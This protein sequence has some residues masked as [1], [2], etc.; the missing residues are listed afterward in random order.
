MALCLAASLTE[1]RRFDPVDQLRRYVNW[2]EDGYQACQGACIDMGGTT[3][4][5]LHRFM[6]Q[7][8]PFA[9]SE[10]P[11][12]SGNGGIMRL[13]PAVLAAA[14]EASA[15]AM[16]IDSSRTTHASPDCL[17]AAELLGRILWRLL[18]GEPLSAVLAN[19]PDFRP[20][21]KSISRIQNGYFR[22]LE[23]KEVSSTGY[24]ISTL[25]AALWSCYHADSFEQALVNAVNLGG[26]AD[27]VGAVTGQIA[28]AAFGANSI[29]TRWLST[30]VWR[31]HLELY[32]DK[33]MGCGCVMLDEFDVDIPEF[34]R[35]LE[36]F[37]TTELPEGRISFDD[38]PALD[39]RLLECP[40]DRLFRRYC[41]AAMVANSMERGFIPPSKLTEYTASIRWATDRYVPFTEPVLRRVMQGII[42]LEHDDVVA[43]L[44]NQGLM[45]KFFSSVSH[46]IPPAST[47]L[48]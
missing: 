33:L 39:P 28:G 15:V 46:F 41:L 21:N 37:A 5:A 36:V 13:A 23:R 47:G 2:Y 1:R 22:L 25:E 26:D 34:D 27:T 14:D 30:L 19:M 40:R 18:D 44:V 9:G 12:T 31:R 7:G 3:S 35:M 6:R 38:I 8:M 4:A 10:E 11:R 42:Y 32:A 45:A 43:T 16:A 17:D 48:L 24:A 29:P 20:R